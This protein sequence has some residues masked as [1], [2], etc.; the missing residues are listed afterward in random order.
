MAAARASLSTWKFDTALFDFDGTI[1]DTNGLIIESWKHTVRALTGREITLDEIRGTLGEV[2]AYSMARIMPE[3]DPA[4]AVA[5]YREYQSDRYLKGIRL[6]DGVA[7]TLAA[8][9]GLHGLPGQS[10]RTGQPGRTGQQGSGVKT[11]LVTSRLANSTYKALDHFGIRQY[12]D[13]ILTV[14]DCTKFKPDPEPILLALERL[15]AAP[16][17]T[18]YLGDTVHDIL[19]SKAAGVFTVLADWSVA[20]PP[21]KRAGAPAADLVIKHMDDL[22]ELF[23]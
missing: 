5:T 13:V 7:E 14:E 1:M 2:I 21:E 11:G 23:R 15:G 3:I 4:V 10:G 9:R 16:E 17:R 6:F 18:I 8:L 12:F 22:L 19:A 20:L